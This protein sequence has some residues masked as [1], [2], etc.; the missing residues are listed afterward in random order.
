[1]DFAAPQSGENEKYANLK[2]QIEEINGSEQIVQD[3]SRP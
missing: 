2:H 1:V 3:V